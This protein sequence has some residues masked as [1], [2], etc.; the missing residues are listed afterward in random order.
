MVSI[1][2][3]LLYVYALLRKRTV[4]VVA[5][6]CGR[7]G[8][9]IYSATHVMA[10]AQRGRFVV[11][12][13][14]LE[15]YV[16]YFQG[17]DRDLFCRY[18][19][20]ITPFLCNIQLFRR[21]YLHLLWHAAKHIEEKQSSRHFKT[22]RLYSL[23]EELILGT[24]EFL[25][26][27]KQ[28]KVLFLFGFT[29]HDFEALEKYSDRIRPYFQPL[30]KNEAAIAEPINYLR[31]KT[32]VIVAVAIRHGDYRI[33]QGGRYFFPIGD[34]AGLMRRLLKLFPGKRVG[35]L[36][37][38]DEDQDASHFSEFTYVFRP[39]NSMDLFSMSR[40]DYIVGPPSTYSGS[41]A[42][43]GNVPILIV[44]NINDEVSIS[45]FASI[46]LINPA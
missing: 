7:L 23:E 42:F 22:I 15:E 40:C 30:L 37:C 35:F 31:G 16:H 4:L 18:P 34:Y 6:K 21:K 45:A 28:H 8:N 46:R 17:S 10:F 36:I 9:R 27:A 5:E 26:M 3:A 44:K 41:S 20:G 11:L 13:P 12:L 2:L 43:I 25:N 33:W 24:S 14:A 32:D 29:I 39:K 38:S 1:V 19:A